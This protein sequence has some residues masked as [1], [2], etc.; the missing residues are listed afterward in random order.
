MFC[1]K[2]M[3]YTK[4]CFTQNRVMHLN[5]VLHKKHFLPRPVQMLCAAG[6]ITLF[7]VAGGASRSPFNCNIKFGTF[8]TLNRQPVGLGT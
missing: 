2:A 6:R 8:R 4:R 1:V 7:M 3:V 5:Y